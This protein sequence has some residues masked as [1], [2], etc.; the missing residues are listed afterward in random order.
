MYI[1]RFVTFTIPI[2][3]VNNTNVATDILTCN[4]FETY[5]ILYFHSYITEVNITNSK[6]SRF[7]TKRKS[8]GS[9]HDKAQKEREVIQQNV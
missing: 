7:N 6:R 8:V 5:I 3:Y 4:I 1:V 2:K 9:L